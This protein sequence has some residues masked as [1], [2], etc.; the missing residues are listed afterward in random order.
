MRKCFV[1]RKKA[2]FHCTEC[3]ILS[4][5]VD[6]PTHTNA[7]DE[8][9][10]FKK[11][12]K[13]L[14][15][16]EPKPLISKLGLL[17]K[18]IEESRESISLLADRIIGAMS[19]ALLSIKK[20]K[21]EYRD[22]L[23]LLSINLTE[24]QCKEIEQHIKHHNISMSLYK[25]PVSNKMPL[26]YQQDI[27]TENPKHIFNNT[28][29]SEECRIADYGVSIISQYI[30]ILSIDANDFKVASML[31]KSHSQELERKKQR[32]IAELIY[33]DTH[34]LEQ[35]LII[36]KDQV[37]GCLKQVSRILTKNAIDSIIN[38][39]S[40]NIPAPNSLETEFYF[41]Y[42]TIFECIEIIHIN[43][44]SLQNYLNKGFNR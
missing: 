40:N 12:K 32:C 23:R 43:N 1:C 3:S 10:G 19:V 9:H 33:R 24:N 39:Q 4:C 42:K 20:Q 35:E 7:Y 27:L 14:S 28:Q 37:A 15:S 18:S 5:R 8:G 44:E 2:S 6:R 13:L 21:N 38:N 31:I 36:L 34:G 26:W 22:L 30:P 17:L 41:I 11:A 16:N 25:T 29:D